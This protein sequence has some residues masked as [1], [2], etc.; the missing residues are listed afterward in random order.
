V[1][2]S[3]QQ[4]TQEFLNM[5]FD[6]LER[7]LKHTP[8][9]HITDSVYGGRISNQ[10]ICHGCGK[11]RERIETF[12]T[13]SLEVRNMKS[14]YDS[15]EKSIAGETIDDYFC[16][17]CKKKNSIT[18]RGCIEY[19]PNVM[20][21]HLQRIVFDL[22]T[23]MNQKINSRLEFPFELNMEPYT[24][25]GLEWRE[26][27]KKKKEKAEAQNDGADAKG[28]EDKAQETMDEPSAE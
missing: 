18:K 4:D 8:F 22:D 10:M 11:V 2:V 16:D 23:L 27:A 7:H 25:E 21:V 14:L 12:Y 9:S 17:E 15:F 28:G 26:K 6:K 24:K 3:V 20:I 1:N 19:L 13:V 5:I